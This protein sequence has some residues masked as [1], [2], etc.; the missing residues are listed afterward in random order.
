MPVSRKLGVYCCDQGW[1]ATEEWIGLGKIHGRTA[2][3]ATDWEID[4]GTRR[5]RVGYSSAIRCNRLFSLHPAYMVLASSSPT[6]AE[7]LHLLGQTHTQLPNRAQQL[8]LLFL[9]VSRFLTYTQSEGAQDALKK[10]HRS[11]A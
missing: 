3:T 11:D 2:R 4:R 9:I 10:A 8:L 1:P 5:R 6:W 7:P